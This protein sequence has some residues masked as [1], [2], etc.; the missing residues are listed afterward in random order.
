[1]DDEDYARVAEYR[2]FVQPVGKH[3][4]A[5][6]PR[7]GYMHRLITDFELT[8]HIDGNGLNNCKSNLRP[9][10]RSVNAQNTGKSHGQYTSDYKGVYRQ[11]G[12]GRR[13]RWRARIHVRGKSIPLGYFE[14]EEEAALAYNEAARKY[15]GPEA[16]VNSIKGGTYVT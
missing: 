12:Y 9:A 5:Y 11:S 13:K 8:D 2:W 14:T 6:H 1:M 15:Y 16:W 4:Y 10:T 7:V 3:T